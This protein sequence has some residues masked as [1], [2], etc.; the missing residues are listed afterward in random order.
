MSC[1]HSAGI[2]ILR[3]NGGINTTKNILATRREF[4]VY[5]GNG[6]FVYVDKKQLERC[7]YLRFLLRSHPIGRRYDMKE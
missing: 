5:S 6:F 3:A 2:T 7:L 1:I 4:F